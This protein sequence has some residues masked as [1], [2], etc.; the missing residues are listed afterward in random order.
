MHIYAERGPDPIEVMFSDEKLLYKRVTS[1]G[2]LALP[3]HN[4]WHAEIS[5]SSVIKSSDNIDPLVIGNNDNNDI[6]H[7]NS[8]G[9]DICDEESSQMK[10]NPT[11]VGPHREEIHYLT[12]KSKRKKTTND[13]KVKWQRVKLSARK[14]VRRWFKEKEKVDTSSELRQ[15]PTRNSVDETTVERDPIEETTNIMGE[16]IV[17]EDREEDDVKLD[18]SD[19]PDWLREALEWPED[20]DIFISLKG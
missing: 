4:N 3:Y 5:S 14:S 20:D 7:I 1:D 16:K 15:S 10:S 8:R 12:N 2:L 11:F 17:H 6:P 9:K 18:Y 19:L 13:K